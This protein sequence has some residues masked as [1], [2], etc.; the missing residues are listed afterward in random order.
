MPRLLPHDIDCFC[1]ECYPMVFDLADTPKIEKGYILTP[2]AIKMTDDDR[3]IVIYTRKGEKLEMNCHHW[4]KLPD[5]QAK[6]ESNV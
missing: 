2:I 6:D 1:S 3:S 5:Y 4:D